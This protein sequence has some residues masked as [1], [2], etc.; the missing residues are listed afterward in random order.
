MKPLLFVVVLFF[1]LNVRGQQNSDKQNSARFG[2]NFAFFGAGDLYGISIYGEYVWR[3]NKVL[4][5]SPRIMSG[6]ASRADFD[7]LNSFAGSV[8]LGIN[9]FPRKSFKIDVGGLYHKVINSYGTLG[10]IQYGQSEI[11]RGY[12][13]SEN[14]FG[15]IGSVSGNLYSN[16]KMELGIRFDLLTSFTEGYFNADSWQIGLYI[17]LKH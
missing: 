14:L 3:L 13:S 7:H 5:V 9:P 15:L 8:S 11:T 1:S 12:H 4:S 17:G 2:S 6:F 10:D 16:K